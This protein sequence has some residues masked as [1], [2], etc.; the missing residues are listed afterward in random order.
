MIQLTAHSNGICSLCSCQGHVHMELPVDINVWLLSTSCLWKKKSISTVFSGDDNG[1]ILEPQ[2]IFL[3]ADK[4]TSTQLPKIDYVLTV[5]DV[6]HITFCCS[7]LKT[8]IISFNPVRLKL[9]SCCFLNI[10]HLFPAID[11]FSHLH[12]EEAWGPE[13]NQTLGDFCHEA[14]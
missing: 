3:T 6:I 9:F 2:R 11:S 1:H 12:I 10:Q 7:S 5:T 8:N 13:E 4:C 14:T